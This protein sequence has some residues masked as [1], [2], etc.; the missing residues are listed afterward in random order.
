MTWD[1]SYFLH[2]IA[3]RLQSLEEVEEIG[4]RVVGREPHY[5]L[6]NQSEVEYS[7]L[8]C[9]QDVHR[10]IRENP[11]DINRLEQLEQKYGRPFLTSYLNADRNLRELDHTEQQRMIQQWVDFYVDLFEQF[12]PDIVLTRG[13]AASHTWIPFDLVQHRGGTAY[14]VFPVR[15][16]DR[17]SFMENT[18]F[19]EFKD[20]S[21]TFENIH[22][23][24]VDITDHSNAYSTAKTYLKDV[25]E[26]GVRPDYFS[27]MTGRKISQSLKNLAVAPAR[28]TKYA[29]YYHISN[30]E[31]NYIRDDHTRPSVMDRIRNDARQVYRRI[32]TQR[33]DFF[34]EP[35]VDEEFVFFPLHYQPEI[36][37]MIGAPMYTNQIAAV[38]QVSDSLPIGH[39]L[40]VKDHPAMGFQRPL[41]YYRRINEIPNVRVLDP[42]V[43]S[44]DLIRHSDLVTTITGTAGF[45]ALKLRKP[46][47]T[48]GN[49]YYNSMP[50]VGHCENPNDLAET[51][52]YKITGYEHDEEQLLE[53]LTAVFTNSFSIPSR[54]NA[55]DKERADALFPHLKRKLFGR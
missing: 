4:A 49:C 13:V 45:E 51:I 9:V 47:I 20:I 3:K 26:H 27:N 44:H 33:L 32:R 50:M 11:L 1:Q 53:F 8:H 52:E 41:A 38:K 43:D 37:L 35:G 14:S 15:I 17:F 22:G 10:N 31:E 21:E 16:G 2:E 54:A 12:E 29:Y 30:D 24:C 34:D 42:K 40:Y 25:R 28:Y 23:G 18:H 5:Y 7:E 55:T 36:A 39:K 19:G 48:I 6:S 46:T